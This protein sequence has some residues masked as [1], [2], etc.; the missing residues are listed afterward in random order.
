VDCSGNEVQDQGHNH[1]KLGWPYEEENKAGHVRSLDSELERYYPDNIPEDQ[2]D[3]IIVNKPMTYIS[4]GYHPPNP[5]TNCSQMAPNR[6]LDG[7]AQDG[8][9]P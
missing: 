6:I 4:D 7:R 5:S 2:G 1:P 9:S 3:E 8:H